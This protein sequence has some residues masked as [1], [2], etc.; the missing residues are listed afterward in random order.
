LE[1]NS[2]LAQTLTDALYAGDAHHRLCQ[3]VVL[4]MG[5]VMMLQA[6]GYKNVSTYHMNEGHAAFL[7]LGLLEREAACGDLSLPTDA[8]REA[9]RQRCVLRCARTHLGRRRHFAISTIVTF[10]N[11]GAT[12]FI[13]AML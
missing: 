9:V 1:D 3:E 4:G 2:K 10:Q 7:T 5:G 6:L 12:T 13:C 8:D 11:G